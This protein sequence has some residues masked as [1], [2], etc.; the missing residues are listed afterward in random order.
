MCKLVKK[1]W[2]SIS[3]QQKLLAFASIVTVVL[4][5]SSFFNFKLVEFSIDGFSDI[6][7]DN[8]RCGAFLEAMEGERDAFQTMM[9][10]GTG[11][12]RHAYEKAIQETKKS[13]LALPYS[14]QTI[15]SR[16]YARTWSIKNAYETYSILR[17]QLVSMGTSDPDYVER[18]YWIY[19]IQ[20]YLVLYGNRLIQ[21]TLNQGNVSYQE[22]A[23]RFSALPYGLL[24]VS[25]I[26]LGVILWLTKVLSDTMVDP[27]LKLSESSARIESGDFSEEDVEIKNQDE[28]GQL[29]RNFNRMKH[30]MEEHIHTLQEKNEMSSRLHREEVER[31]ETEKR[32]EAARMELLKSQINPHFLFNTLSMIACTAKL[33]EAETT[34]KMITSMSSL[35]RYNLKTSEQIVALKQELD[36]VQNYIYI[37]KM[38]F[39]SR[40]AYETDIRTDAGRI[41]IPAFTMQPI[42]ENAIIH[43]LSKKEAGGRII[44]R[45]WERENQVVISVADNGLGMDS[46]RLRELRDGLK[47]GKTAKVG[48]GLGNISKRIHNMYQRGNVQIYST[49]GRGTVIQMVI[50]Q[51]EEPKMW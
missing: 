17:D 44:V 45:A 31:I 25:G 12:S 27:V 11:E 15:G 29:V 16:R 34:E 13:V 14:H 50:P 49:E 21:E 40:V 36:V 26:M 23:G 24:I 22:K 32:L 6:L 43:G 51:D 39:G 35:F 20:D 2:Y 10:E 47:G 28:M 3:L 30:A 19:D 9:R 42:V 1:I 38:R 18:L 7:N 37:Q 41:R 48:I 8:A 46:Q 4:V 5:V 33:E